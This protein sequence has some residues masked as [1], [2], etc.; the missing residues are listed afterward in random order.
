M[1]TKYIKP[2]INVIKV[3]P[4][5]MQHT[6]IETNSYKTDGN[7]QTMA[8]SRKSNSSWDEEDEEDMD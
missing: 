2:Y 7:A 5:V 6:S 8:A 1:K 4:V 3:L